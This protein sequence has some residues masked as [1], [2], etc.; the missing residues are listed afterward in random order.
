MFALKLR[1]KL[2]GGVFMEKLLK[3]IINEEWVLELKL[4]K[5]EKVFKNKNCTP[6][7]GRREL[8]IEHIGRD[9]EWW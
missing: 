1:N 9:G 8:E 4:K 2:L 7:G 5:A 6:N 3:S